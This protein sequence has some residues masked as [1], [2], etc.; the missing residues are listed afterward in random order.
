MELAPVLEALCHLVVLLIVL[1]LA[2]LI[3]VQLAPTLVAV[4]KHHNSGVFG[5]QIGSVRML[6]GRVQ[7]ER[8]G[9]EERG[10]R[11][12]VG[13]VILRSLRAPVIAV[14]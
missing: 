2:V 13:Q 7:R 5:R 8:Q 9:G 6:L 4:G 11:G 10:Q 3:T 1:E 14:R 12:R